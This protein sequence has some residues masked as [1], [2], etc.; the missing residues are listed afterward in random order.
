MKGVC[1]P[2]RVGGGAGMRDVVVCAVMTLMIAYQGLPSFTMAVCGVITLFTP[3]EWPPMPL[4]P[5]HARHLGASL[6]GT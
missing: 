2:R 1:T 5:L 3:P 4:R 6:A